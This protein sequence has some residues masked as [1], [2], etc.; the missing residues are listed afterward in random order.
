M[1]QLYVFDAALTEFTSYALSDSSG[2]LNS[3]DTR[4]LPVE[5]DGLSFDE[6]VSRVLEWAKKVPTAKCSGRESL[7]LL[8]VRQL[9]R[10]AVL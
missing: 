2:I 3:S 4:A 1:H 5:F 6:I 7:L 9:R 10:F 8:H